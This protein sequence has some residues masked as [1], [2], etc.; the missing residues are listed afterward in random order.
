MRAAIHYPPIRHL[1]IALGAE[2][3]TFE[4]GTPGQGTRFALQQ[5]NASIRHLT[6]L[7]TKGPG[8]PSAETTCCILTASVL[9]IYLA[10]I[11]GHFLE[12]FQHVKSAVKV[13]QDFERS[14]QKHD[15]PT[16]PSY[17]VPLSQLRSLIISI[18]G[19]LRAMVND[20]SLEAGSPDILVSDVKPATIFSSV[21]EAHTYVEETLFHNTLAFLQETS[22]NPHPTAEQLKVAVARHRKLCQAL[23]SS[24]NALDVMAK[25]LLDAGDTQAQDG[26]V[27]L[28]IYHLLLAVRLRIDIFRPEERESAFDDLEAHLEEMLR[29]CEVLVQRQQEQEVSTGQPSCSSGLGYVMPL[30]MVAARC[31]NPRLRRRAVQLLL[32]CPRREGIWD[33]QLAGRIV[34]QTIEME[35]QAMGLSP[36]GGDNVPADRRIREV[37]LDFQGERTA[38]VRFVTVGDWKQGRLGSQRLIEW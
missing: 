14:L 30:H 25:G 18:Y 32:N 8:G 13:L 29:H 15:G 1:V 16:S 35:E 20:V 4:A 31:R 19:Q 6:T 28:R 2:Y 37:K 7:H 11:R 3:E 38:A 17:P 23:S 9:F 12:A 10:S 24:E 22:L 33:A 26:I 5:C 34:S 36:D 27:I 21:R